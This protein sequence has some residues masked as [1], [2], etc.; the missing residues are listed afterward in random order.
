MATMMGDPP[1]LLE[2][3]G[4]QSYFEGTPPL[5]K[6]VGYLVVLGFGAAFSIFT[7]I[8]VYMNQYFG[9]TGEATSE[10]FK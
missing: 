3:A 10:H 7:T 4:E 1:T 5:S 8:I 2:H 9:V 6:A